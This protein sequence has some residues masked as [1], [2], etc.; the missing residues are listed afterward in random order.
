MNRNHRIVEITPEET[1]AIRHEVMWPDKPSDYVRL[2]NDAEGKH[3]GLFVDN[4]MVSVISLFIESG[5]AQFRKFA[6]L[7]SYQGKGYGTLLLKEVFKIA[8][9]S[10]SEK[11]WCNARRDKGEY[12]ARFGMR[13][14]D[15]T[16]VKG[17]IEYV[18]MEKVFN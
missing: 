6:T 3:Y 18:I 5:H 8:Q 14:T 15:R 17:G 16:F 4:E 12:Y 10:N 1:M 13:L 9:C 2:P 7:F 11:I